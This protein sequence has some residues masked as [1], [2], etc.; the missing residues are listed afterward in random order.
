LRSSL[1]PRRRLSRRSSCRRASRRSRLC[2]NRVRDAFVRVRE[3]FARR[4]AHGLGGVHGNEPGGWFAAESLLDSLRPARARSYCA[5]REP[6]GDEAFVRTTDQLGRLE[7]PLSGSPDGPPMAQMAA[8]S[9]MRSGSSSERAS[10][11]ARIVGVLLQPV[12]EWD[13]IPRQTVATSQDERART[14]SRDA[15]AAVNDRIRY[16]WE[17]LYDRNDPNNPRAVNGAAPTMGGGGGNT[18]RGIPNAGQA[19]PG[20]TSSLGLGRHVPGL[21]TLLVEMGQEQGLDRRIQLHIDLASEVAT[22]WG[23]CRA[24][25]RPICSYFASPL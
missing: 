10:R 22:G 2:G 12:S 15:I 1:L 13:G 6:I 19:V 20:G 14:L 25:L 9:P 24:A 16:S 7:S 11:Y 23:L 17:R 5:A 8:Q 4:G 18:G 21:S 3:R